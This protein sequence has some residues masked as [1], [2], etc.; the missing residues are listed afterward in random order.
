MKKTIIALVVL[1]ISLA[2]GFFGAKFAD[3]NGLFSAKDMRLE[4]YTG[5]VAL[6]NGSKTKEA[7]EGARLSTGDD[8]RTMLASM[9]YL[10]LDETKILA[11]DEESNILITQDDQFYLVNVVSG[12]VFFNVT[13]PLTEEES[14][15]F[16]T[17]NVVTGVRGTSGIITYHPGS[18]TTQI[19]VTSG[20]VSGTSSTGEVH[21]L[22]A[23]QVGIVTTQLDGSVTFEVKELEQQEIYHYYQ[24]DFMDFL[25]NDLPPTGEE[26][27][28]SDL[29]RL[30]NQ[31]TDITL[32]DW[33]QLAGEQ[34]VLSLDR[35]AAF[36]QM[37]QTANPDY[38]SFL[39]GGGELL[40]LLGHDS[41][42]YNPGNGNSVT[43]DPR[44]YQW[45]G[46]NLTDLGDLYSIYHQDG[47]FFAMNGPD[48]R[49]Q[50]GVET[51]VF[52][53]YPFDQGVQ[54]A[55]PSILR[56]NQLLSGI[57]YVDM[58]LVDLVSSAQEL[59]DYANQTGNGSSIALWTPQDGWFKGSYDEILPGSSFVRYT[60][61]TLTQQEASAGSH[62]YLWNP[63]SEI[64]PLL[65][66]EG[67]ATPEPSPEAEEPAPETSSVAEYE[68]ILAEYRALS[69]ADPGSYLDLLSAGTYF[70]YDLFDVNGDGVEEL[71]VY[72]DGEYLTG[73]YTLNNG[74]V[75]NILHGYAFR[76][77]F[78]VKSDGTLS[79]GTYGFMTYTE[80]FRYENGEK[81]VLASTETTND[82]NGQPVY[83]PDQATFDSYKNLPDYQPN[84]TEFHRV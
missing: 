31:P 78:G 50:S 26:V 53:F 66:G 52:G 64:L 46:T 13:A 69:L 84:L 39:D 23:G 72:L 70:S 25:Q 42:Y 10:L 1:G 71:L 18:L 58:T 7:V 59:S 68:P 30:S 44:Y 4:R 20:T 77:S 11:M 28:L 36:A 54:A 24:D 27:R 55:T 32:P 37:I 38:V 15:E 63:A 82:T 62:P 5:Q 83:T 49:S 80:F 33:V 51:H 45:D 17:N 65:Q 35:A 2:I 40:L 8:L 76:V 75:E 47:Q 12:S 3:E 34:R 6:S 22:Q 61:L 60:H 74:Q 81:V 57:Q 73:V 48:T 43:I 14:L 56:I 16:V 19:I 29:A 9:A 41:T 67:G 79:S 21:D